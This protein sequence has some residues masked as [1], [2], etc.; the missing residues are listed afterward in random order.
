MRVKTAVNNNNPNGCQ[1]IFRC[2]YIIFAVVKVDLAPLEGECRSTVLFIIKTT[3]KTT[4]K[5]I[6][7]LGME[8]SKRCNA[9]PNKCHLNFPSLWRCAFYEACHT[10]YIHQSILWTCYC[11]YYSYQYSSSSNDKGGIPL[12][13][14]FSTGRSWWKQQRREYSEAKFHFWMGS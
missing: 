10:L 3:W 12:R 13:I 11:Y 4:M 1:M 6:R 5:V 8:H 14:L 7:M 2:I 9:I